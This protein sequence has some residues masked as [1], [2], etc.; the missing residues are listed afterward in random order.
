MTD[1][2]ISN[3]PFVNYANAYWVVGDDEAHVYSSSRRALVAVDDPEYVEWKKDRATF[4]VGSLADLKR[5]LATQGLDDGN[6]EHH[7]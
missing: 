4:R 5:F 1:P 7:S 6:G 3:L 2:I